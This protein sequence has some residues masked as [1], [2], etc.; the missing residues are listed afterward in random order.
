MK[1]PAH[2]DERSPIGARTNPSAAE[3]GACSA[4]AREFR[5]FVQSLAAPQKESLRETYRHLHAHPELSFAEFATSAYLLKQLR[6][7]G[8]EVTVAADGIS[9]VAVLCGAQP[10]PVIAFRADLDALPIAEETGLPYASQTPGVM[11][12]CGHDSHAAVLL[13]L[14]RVLAAHTDLV[15]GKVKLLFQSAEEKLPGGAKALCEAGVMEDVDAIYAFH[16]SSMLPLGVVATTEGATSACI[17]TYDIAIHG[18]S[19][20]ICNPDQALN[21]VPVACLLGSAVN[22]L[23]AEKASPLE[24]AVLT[25]SYIRGGQRENIIASEAALGGSVRTFSNQLTGTLFARLRETAAGICAA[26]GCTCDVTTAVGYPA[27]INT[28][29][30]TALIDRAVDALGLTRRIT[31]PAMNGEDFSYYLLEKPGSMCYVGM[32]VEDGTPMPHHN[33]RFRL[34]EAG[35]EI[36][37][38]LEL[39]IY[40]LASEQVAF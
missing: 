21:P 36:A 14:A 2:A 5:A 13:A 20:H 17:G 9:L 40:L 18:R 1:T 32:A 38:E 31:E 28:P 7:A 10:G 8:L 30:E 27:A 29:A 19:G 39:A 16:C 23:L 15:R 34:N 6:A 3:S 35:L 33:C 12:A 4:E 24:K 25:V 11:H 22:Q 37:L 26:Y